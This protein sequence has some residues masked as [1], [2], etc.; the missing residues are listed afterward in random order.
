M[1]EEPVDLSPVM[2]VGNI[3]VLSQLGVETGAALA[4]I[5]LG[6]AYPSGK[7]ATTWAAVEDQCTAGD[8]GDR[9]DT[10]YREGIYVGYRFFDSFG[11]DVLFPF[12]Y[13]LGYTDFSVGKASVKVNGPEVEVSARITNKGKYKGKET[14]Q[15][16][17]SCPHGRL[18]RE[19]K[20]LAGFAKTDELDPGKAGQSRSGL[21]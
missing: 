6:K 12:G 16:Y 19:S 14:L 9:D 10:R 21:I 13:G 18:D 17:V 15:V 8:F 11:L 4:D 2:E 5:M 3:L 7:L 1:P 20:S